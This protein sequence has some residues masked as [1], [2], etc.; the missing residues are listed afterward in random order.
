MEGLDG[1]DELRGILHVAWRVPHV[2]FE[3]PS[4]ILGQ[5]VGWGADGADDG[6]ERGTFLVDLQEPIQSR[7]LK[8]C[9][10]SCWMT[11]SGSDNFLRRR[12]VFC[13]MASVCDTLDI[14]HFQS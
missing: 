1:V 7:C 12:V 13:S 6:S 10:R 4:Q 5:A 11:S 14:Q 9:G 8:P 3:L 2:F